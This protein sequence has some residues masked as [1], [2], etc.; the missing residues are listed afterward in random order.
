MA[1][2]DCS[3]AMTKEQHVVS[4]EHLGKKPQSVLIFIKVH[5]ERE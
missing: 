1:D 5:V 4:R 3:L 2:L